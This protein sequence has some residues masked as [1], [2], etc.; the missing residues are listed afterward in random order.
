MKNSLLI[1]LFIILSCGGISAQTVPNGGFENWTSVTTGTYPFET[2][3]FWKTTDSISLAASLGFVHS[4]VKEATE[5]HGGNYALKLTGWSALGSPVPAAA[6]NG[7]IDIATLSI[8]K[9]TP[10]TVRHA[11]LNGHFKYIPI[12]SD[13]CDVMVSML[14][15]NSLTNSRDTIGYGKFSTNSATSGT[16][17]SPFEITL[18]YSSTDKPDTMVILIL[19]SPLLIGSGHVGTTLYIDDLSFTGV[20]GIDEVESIINTVELYPSPASSMI[21]IRVDLKKPTPL[22][23]SIYDLQGKYVV[24]E[25]LEPFET[26]VDVSQLPAGN[27]TLNL[28]DGTRRAYFTSFLIAR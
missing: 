13:T 18:D 12:G 8:V 16:N 17:Y 10:D 1:S 6:S 7:D 23:Y 25:V 4:V 20:V 27:Y 22:V 19:T 9:G 5:V 11:K 14:K 28:M 3:D 26:R 2:P 15:W 21:T 24:S